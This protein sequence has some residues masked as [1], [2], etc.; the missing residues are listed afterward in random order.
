MRVEEFGHFMGIKGLRPVQRIERPKATIFIAETD[1]ET[2]RPKEFPLGYYQTVFAIATR[3]SKGKMDLM[4][5]L[6]FD[7]FHDMEE[8]WTTDQKR[9]ARINM[10]IKEADTFIKKNVEAGRI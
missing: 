3:A 8:G 4:S 10:T 5:F 2:D 1:Y 6:E 9:N 7:A